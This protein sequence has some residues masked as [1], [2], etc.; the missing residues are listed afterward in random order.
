MKYAVEMGLGAMICI[1]SFIKNVSGI[2]KLLGGG[3]GGTHT[4]S[5]VIAKAQNLLYQNKESR[6]KNAVLYLNYSYLSGC[7]TDL[8]VMTAK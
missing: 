6:L 8:Y 4:E 1:S 2:Q 3:G 5:M 7:V